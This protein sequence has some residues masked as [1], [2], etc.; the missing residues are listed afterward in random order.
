MVM[1][2]WFLFPFLHGVFIRT[3]PQQALAFQATSFQ[4]DVIVEQQQQQ[5]QQVIRS[6]RRSSPLKY[7]GLDSE[8]D[9]DAMIKIQT[10]APPV[11]DMKE[12]LSN[13]QA[14][15]KQAGSAAES[16]IQ[17]TAMNSPLIR[18]LLLNQV[19]ILALGVLV[20][21]LILFVTDGGMEGFANLDEILNWSKAPYFSLDLTLTP[22]RLLIGALGA[23]PIIIFG[24]LVENSD[25]SALANI[26]FSTIT[27]VM[28]LFGRRKSPPDEFLPAELKG[29]RIPTTSTVDVLVQSL[30]LSIGTG[31]CEETVFR[32]LVPALWTHYHVVF[33]QNAASLSIIATTLCAQAVLFALGHGQPGSSLANNGIVLGLQFVN[34]L[35][36]GIIYELT[37]GDLVSAM[38]SHALYDFGVFFKTWLDVNAQLE[39]A[40][41]MYFEKFP[42]DIQRQVDLVL[43]EYPSLKRKTTTID[44]QTVVGKLKKLFYTFDFNKNQ[45]LDKSEVRKGFAYLALERAG[46]PPP[47]QAVDREFDKYTT[48]SDDKANPQSRLFFPDCLRLY[49]NTVGKE[50]I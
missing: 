9:N 2:Y 3:L 4:Y 8:D 22:M 10:R 13:M 33:Q 46:I 15:N 1:R 21:G 35:S 49:A 14:Q 18:A 47:Q 36:F 29:K 19:F 31:I 40:E 17:R 45:S 50:A 48:S 25:N 41:R 11:F 42:P 44:G 16:K 39:Y 43:A 37:G 32:L 12:N 23:I 5:Q 27:M 24:N 26:N 38:V 30:A 20:S 28:T 34:G 6:R 7:R